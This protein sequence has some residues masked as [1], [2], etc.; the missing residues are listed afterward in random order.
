M[1]VVESNTVTKRDVILR[2]AWKLIRHYGYTKTTIQDIAREAGVGK[3]TLY[4]S[5]RSKSDIMLALVD[6][7]SERITNDLDAISRKNAPPERRLRE[8]FLHRV[9]TI[10]DLVHRYPH[11][12]EVISSMK[13]E[14][15]RR[16]DGFVKKQGDIFGRIIREGVE[17]GI[18]DVS[19][20]EETGQLL[21]GLYEH[22][23]PPYYRFRSRGSLEQFAGSVTELL[24]DGMRPGKIPEKRTAAGNDPARDLHEAGGRR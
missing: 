2:A 23:T 18:F 21:A 3:G 24:L 4:L 11:G 17:E 14:I 20:P 22:F 1:P 19:D 12:E 16:I 10:Y 13:P 6:R 15:V 9:M 8:C 7:T 5:F